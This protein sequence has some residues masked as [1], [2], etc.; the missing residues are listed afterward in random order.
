MGKPLLNEAE[1]FLLDHWA[2]ARLLEEAME[3][4]REKYKQVYQWI[5][6][7]VTQA[8]PKLDAFRSYVTQFW[9]SGCIGFGRKAWPIGD[10]NWPSGLWVWDV[11][12]ELLATEDSNAPSASIWVPKKKVELDLETVRAAVHAAAKELLSP[13]ELKA[14][15]KEDS[16]DHLLWLPAPSKK[17]ILDAFS[18]DDGQGMVTL[19]VSQFDLMARFIPVLDTAFRTA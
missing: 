7:A 5:T 9:G 11:R 12:L 10:P 8:H 16:G 15:I 19:F 3:S 4:V 14:T 13:D 18:K 6:D 17:D 1:R 2:D